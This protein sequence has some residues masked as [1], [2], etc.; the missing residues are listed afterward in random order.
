ML[1]LNKFV[2]SI[3]C[4]INN[5]LIKIDTAYLSNEDYLTSLNTNLTIKNNQIFD[6]NLLSK[7]PNNEEFKVSIR[8][9][10]NKEKITT[11]FTNYAKPLVKKY[12]FI[13]GFDEGSLDFY[14]IKKDFIIR[15]KSSKRSSSFKVE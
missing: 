13:N 8:T 2:S 1:W 10:Q 9:N 15:L 5:I 11:V 3:L 14:S 7:F 6:L 4:K 12:K